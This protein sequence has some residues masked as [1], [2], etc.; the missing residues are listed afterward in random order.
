MSEVWENAETQNLD[1]CLLYHSPI[2]LQFPNSF[3]FIF[4]LRD[5][6]N[7]LLNG[8]D[9]YFGLFCT[10]AHRGHRFHKEKTH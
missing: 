1:K 4:S 5:S 10:V 9:F 8:F 7:H 3:R 6:E 2:I